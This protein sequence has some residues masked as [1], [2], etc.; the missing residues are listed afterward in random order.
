ML[1]PAVRTV[2]PK[3]ALQI[4]GLELSYVAGGFVGARAKNDA[5][6]SGKSMVIATETTLYINFLKK[7]GVEKSC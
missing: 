6:T 7:I 3:H 1:S 2:S 4:C 5:K